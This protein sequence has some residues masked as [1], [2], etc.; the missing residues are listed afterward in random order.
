MKTRTVRLGELLEI[1]KGKKAE[2]LLDSLSR[3]SRRYLQIDDL[4]PDAKPK[5]VEPFVCPLATPTDVIIAWDGA[6]AG[7]VSCNL[8]GF[9]GS[10]LAILRPVSDR[11]YP[12][13][14]ARFLEGKFDYLQAHS[15]GATIP[16]INKDAL[17]SLGLP[18]PP[19]PEQQ[20][21][22][23]KLEDA[24]RLRRTRRYTIELSDAFL[25]AVFLEMFG[26][27]VRNARGWPASELEEL[28]SVDRGKFTPRP[29]NDPSYYGGSLPFIQTG[30]I[31]NSAGRLRSWTQTLNEKGKSVSRS[32]Q[33]GTIVI[34]IVG[35]TI[36]MTAILEIEVYCPDSVVG[37][38]VDPAKASSEYIEFLLRFW[39]PVFLAQAPETARANINLDTLRPLRIP[40]PPLALQKRF[41]DQV[42][43]H[44]RLKTTQ[45]ESLRQAEHLFQS[46]LHQAF[47]VD[48]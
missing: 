17:E 25:P 13:Y 29:R 26:D 1:R 4:R 3:T 19:L 47:E 21:I 45:R 23:R 48:L 30:D 18:L 7:T 24:D 38:Q 22:A 16:H 42:R 15:T 41:A 9:I 46:L 20:R 6:N 39:R 10:T 43:G 33:P 32:F 11:V 14:L 40:V 5:F 31:S 36:G 2:A 44:E 28:G 27:P 12:A 35:A 8:D 37:I 34:A